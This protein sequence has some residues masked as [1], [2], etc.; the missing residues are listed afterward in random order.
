MEFYHHPFSKSRQYP[1]S[2]IKF[3][4]VLRNKMLNT[5]QFSRYL[6]YAVGEIFL[7]VIGILIALSIN[8]W[9]EN[10][11]DA[12]LELKILKNL[13]ED[14]SFNVGS[15]KRVYKLDSIIGSRNR[16]LLKILKEPKSEYND[17]LQIHFGKISRFDVFLPRKMAYEALKSEG[18]DI[19]KNDSLRSEVIELYDETYLLN[20]LMIDLKKD[21]HVTS[22]SFFNQSLFTLEDVGQ[23]VPNDF[24]ALKQD[25]EF[26]NTLSYIAAES[27]NFQEH[28]SNI[29]NKTI[30]V[31]ESIMKE[32]KG[33]GK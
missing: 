28:L 11:K 25:H 30:G 14:I 16:R 13:N 27:A 19:I 31:Q 9:N 24:D 7:V 6:L 1:K 26:I 23:K 5:N 20:Q 18:L 21:I 4:R 22:I 12:I 3:F 33:K 8:N 10:R 2:M 15:I 17:S 32:I 29:L